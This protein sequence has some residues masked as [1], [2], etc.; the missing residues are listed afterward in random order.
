MPYANRAHI[1]NVCTDR[2]NKEA[3]GDHE[4][5]SAQSVNN[6]T[7]PD[8][9]AFSATS[10]AR[11]RIYK[12]LWVVA[13]Q[14]RCRAASD[15]NGRK[16]YARHVDGD[17][18]R[19]GD[20][21]KHQAYALIGLKQP[22][23]SCMFTASMLSMKWQAEAIRRQAFMYAFLISALSTAQHV[24]MYINAGASNCAENGVT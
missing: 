19:A 4:I 5:I 15:I 14:R 7:R 20:G 16:S 8:G 3:A 24:R 9:M 17:G 18:G 1:R 2:A 12:C 6:S 11:Q 13:Q 22:G 21:A 10:A 23:V